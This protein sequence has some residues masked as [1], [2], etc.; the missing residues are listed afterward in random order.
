M[1]RE[2]VLEGDR[3]LNHLAQATRRAECAAFCAREVLRIMRG[4]PETQ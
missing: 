2:T 4:G 3:T 1:A